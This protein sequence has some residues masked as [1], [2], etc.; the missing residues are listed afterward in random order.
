MAY[1][2]LMLPMGRR[3]TPKGVRQF[4]YGVEHPSELGTSWQFGY[5]PKVV[6]ALLPYAVSSGITRMR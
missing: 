4:A 2:L 3:R 6:S 5:A 1:A